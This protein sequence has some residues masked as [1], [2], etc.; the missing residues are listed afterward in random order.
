MAR[1]I[2]NEQIRQYSLISLIGCSLIL[3]AGNLRAQEKDDSV[4]PYI[5]FDKTIGQDNSGVFKGIS[6]VEK[7]MVIGDRHK[8]FMQPNFVKGSVKY[9]GQDYY[10][11]DLKYDVF[12]D[13]LIVR[14]PGIIGSPLVQLFKE[15]ISRFQIE[16]HHFIRVVDKTSNSDI[17]GFV[18]VIREGR[19]LAFYKKHKKSILKKSAEGVV[20]YQFKD[21]WQYFIGHNAG[22]FKIKTIKDINT[23]FPDYRKQLN[24]IGAKYKGLKKSDFENYI[25]SILT[26]FDNLL[27]RSKQDEL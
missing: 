8:F 20:Y 14:H 10:D 26:D 22:F 4:T 25:G 1:I 7:Y 2:L 21:R 15:R 5:W 27:T 17:S 24:D 23:L 9:E 16:G 19:N 13:E 12:A 3:F 11:L 6:Y 18:E